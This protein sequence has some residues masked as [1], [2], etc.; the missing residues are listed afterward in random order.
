VRD[1][2]QRRE[3]IFKDARRAEVDLGVDLYSGEEA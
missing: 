3:K 2:L 1:L